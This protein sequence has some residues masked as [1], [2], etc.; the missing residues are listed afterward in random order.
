[1]IY[2]ILLATA[3]VEGVQNGEVSA[4]ETGE[5]EL[6][7]QPSPTRT[8]QANRARIKNCARQPSPGSSSTAAG[9]GD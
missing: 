5:R 6:A 7:L 8:R 2:N 4:R 3:S 9:V 1:M